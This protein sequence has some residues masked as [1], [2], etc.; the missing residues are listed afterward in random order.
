MT[1]GDPSFLGRGWA[2]PPAFSNGGADVEMVAGAADV[3]ESLQILL[4]TRPGERLMRESFGCE[5]DDVAFEEIDER[6]I[7]RVTRMVSDAIG[8][9]EPRIDLDR[10]RVAESEPGTLLIDLDYSI[11]GANSRFNMVF[12][13]CVN[14]ASASAG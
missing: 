8:Y 12:P 14:E 10:L 2:F 7:N 9:H 1:A 11:R 5:L 6:L 3:H 13:F 4:G